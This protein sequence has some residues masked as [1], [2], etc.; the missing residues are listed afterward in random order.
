MHERRVIADYFYF[1]H[2]QSVTVGIGDDAAV[3]RP[4]TNAQL[5]VS[6]DTLVENVHFFS[7][8]APFFLA[9]K[10]AAVSLS[11]MAAMG[12]RPLWMTVALTATKGADWLAAFAN[13]LRNSA[14]EFDYAIIGGDLSRGER[15]SVTT[16]AIGTVEG[17]PI[18]RGGATIGDDVWLSGATG[19]AALAVR[20][21]QKILPIPENT[22][23]A[24]VL[25]RLD[26]PTPRVAL[27]FS[28][29]GIASAAMDLSDGLMLAAEDVAATS[30]VSIVLEFPRLPVAAALHCLSESARNEL[31]LAGG[32]DYELLFCAPTTKHAQVLAASN[33]TA[34]CIGQVV[35]GEGV[36]VR[37]VNGQ[38]INLSQKGYEHDFCD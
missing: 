27:G 21:R 3:V 19:E 32:D 24:T 1:S 10:A 15:V 7:D 2:N 34:Y 5:A 36:I 6:T 8:A 37:D 25:A 16:T 35:A 4:P 22:D 18:V 31:M 14:A 23:Y 33:G 13:G 12:A 11:D 17:T 20:W 28:L 38:E 30:G 9:R 26:N 29:R